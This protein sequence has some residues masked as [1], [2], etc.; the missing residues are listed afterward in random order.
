M[1]HALTVF[2]EAGGQALEELGLAVSDL[3]QAFWADLDVPVGVLVGRRIHEMCL[4]L[5]LADEPSSWQGVAGRSQHT[6]SAR[7]RQGCSKTDEADVTQ[8]AAMLR[9][10]DVL[11]RSAGM[12]KKWVQQRIS[13]RLQRRAETAR[14]SMTYK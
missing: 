14:R 7:L 4:Y 13:A 6:I 12:C 9:A 8:W 11:E 2:L 3:D 5:V 1:P 10:G